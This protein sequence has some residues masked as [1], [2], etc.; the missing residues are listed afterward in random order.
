MEFVNFADSSH[1]VVDSKSLEAPQ[2][3]ADSV[4]RKWIMSST[5][6]G[7]LQNFCLEEIVLT[8]RND[9]SGNIGQ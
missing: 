9:S 4:L 6:H 3:I 1:F 5:Q 8:E 7:A 2:P